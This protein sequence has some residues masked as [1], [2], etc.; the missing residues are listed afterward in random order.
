M[1]LCRKA[2]W[3]NI[4]QVIDGMGT[5]SLGN[6]ICL[7]SVLSSQTGAFHP[8]IRRTK[9]SYVIPHALSPLPLYTLKSEF[10][11]HQQQQDLHVCGN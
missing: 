7:L 1:A 8:L 2:P 9:A 6:A 11:L 5:L 4:K 3:R 10:H